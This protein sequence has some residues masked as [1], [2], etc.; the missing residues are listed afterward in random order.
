VI[1]LNLRKKLRGARGDFD[2]KVSL[3]IEKGEFLVIFG[4]SGSGK[5]TLLRM[6][7]GLETPDEGYLEI[8]G[9]V[10][11]DT[12]RK[13]NLPPQKREIGFVFQDYALFPNMTVFENIA[14]GMKKKDSKR[15]RELLRIAG[16]EKL[17]ETKPA[18]LSGGQKQRVALLRALAREPRLLLLDE[19]FSAL[20]PQ[21]A[22]PLREE[23]K[24][25]QKQE[26]ITTIMVSHHE[27]DVLKLADRIVHLNEGK[28]LFQGKPEEFFYMRK[29]QSPVKSSLHGLLLEKIFNHDHYEI[30]L[31][32][33]TE[34]LTLKINQ[35]LGEKLK[36]GDKI[37]LS[38]KDFE[39]LEKNES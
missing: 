20:D 8:E 26:G 11:I 17:S 28:V 39:F 1:R 24:K 13:I 38:I 35:T 5:T 21:T 22:A 37:Y 33:K 18:T 2:L 16:L 23:V 36:V 25:L 27:E 7:A 14:Y 31:A 10:W 3:E 12:N 32:L 15:I 19:P 30:T 34:I 9:K 6:L 4:P 29:T